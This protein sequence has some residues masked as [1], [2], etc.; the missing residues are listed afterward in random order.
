M[1]FVFGWSDPLH[2]LD[3]P[4]CS[5]EGKQ[6]LQQNLKW[7]TYKICK[8][9]FDCKYNEWVKTKSSQVEKLYKNSRHIDEFALLCTFFIVYILVWI[10][11]FW[12]VPTQDNW[13]SPYFVM[14]L[15]LGYSETYVIQ[16]DHNNTSCDWKVGVKMLTVFLTNGMKNADIVGCMVGYKYP[17]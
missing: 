14:N 9:I 11:S 4:E 10:C 13:Q 5:T 1:T 17:N 3:S 16:S 2:N 6:D 12:M 7:E 15:D 8:I